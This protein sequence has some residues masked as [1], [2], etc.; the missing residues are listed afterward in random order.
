M[1]DTP[2]IVTTTGHSEDILNEEVQRARADKEK[3][4][5]DGLQHL[6][7]AAESVNLEQSVA[8]PPVYLSQLIRTKR[9]AAGLS[10]TKLA[11]EIGV[12]Q[13]TIATWEAG[14]RPDSR[15]FPAIKDF[16]SIELDEEVVSILDAYNERNKL[17]AIEVVPATELFDLTPRQVLNMLAQAFVT[18]SRKGT[19]TPDQ[20]DVFKSLIDYYQQADEVENH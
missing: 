16:L 4:V 10:Q 11:N 13:Q 2:E 3:T 9:R 7:V 20:T 14:G 12:T 15:Y 8:A 19:L 1:E 17:S 18:S 5:A 6:G